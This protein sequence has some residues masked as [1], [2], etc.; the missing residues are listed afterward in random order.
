MLSGELDVYDRMYLNRFLADNDYRIVKVNLKDGSAR[1]KVESSRAESNWSL[2][3]Q[4]DTYEE[5]MKVIRFITSKSVVS[6]EVVYV[7]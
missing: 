7:Q 4:R 3:T 1:Y 6:E 5:C 2:I